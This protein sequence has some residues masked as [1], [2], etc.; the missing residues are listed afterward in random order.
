MNILRIRIL[1][2]FTYKLPQFIKHKELDEHHILLSIFILMSVLARVALDFFTVNTGIIN[3]LTVFLPISYYILLI[4]LLMK[5]DYDFEVEDLNLSSTALEFVKRTTQTFRFE[6]RFY[7]FEIT[8]EAVAL[9]GDDPIQQDKYLEEIA[10]ALILNRKFKGK[11]KFIGGYLHMEG[12]SPIDTV[13]TAKLIKALH[14]NIESEYIPS[15]M[16]AGVNLIESN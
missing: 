2:I 7:M 4:I 13:F 11:V 12:D 15:L 1:D 6:V 8:K 16:E 5:N 14:L 9:L 3:L 10:D